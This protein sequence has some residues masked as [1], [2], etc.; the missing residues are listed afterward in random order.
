MYYVGEM[1]LSLIGGGSAKYG[2]ANMLVSVGGGTSLIRSHAR[3][4]DG[5]N[6]TYKAP[7][8][9]ITAHR[10]KMDN[11]DGDLRN[12]VIRCLAVHIDDRPELEELAQEVERNVRGKQQ[13]HYADK[14]YYNNESDVAIRRIAGE[15]MCNAKT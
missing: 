10:A 1:M 6:P 3:D 8:P 7:Q 12:L 2:S 15:L 4:L 13:E 14:Q 9:V 11:L 5:L